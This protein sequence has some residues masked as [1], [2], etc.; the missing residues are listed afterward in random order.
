MKICSPEVSWDSIAA[1]LCNYP[2][3]CFCK[4]DPEEL[5]EVA[6]RKFVLNE[7]TLDLMRDASDSHERD[8]VCI[9]AMLDV[10][11]EMADF[12]ISQDG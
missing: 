9:V 3:K 12:L 6:W 10:G 11:E 5:V 4:F 8:I 2:S 1:G 7:S